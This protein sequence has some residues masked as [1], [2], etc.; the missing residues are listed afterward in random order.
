MYSTVL[1]ANAMI[2]K[3]IWGIR[4]WNEIK[5][6][7]N[8]TDR[9]TV[10]LWIWEDS[11]IQFIWDNGNTLNNDVVYKNEQWNEVYLYDKDLLKFKKF[12]VVQLNNS[13][14]RT[15]LKFYIEFWLSWKDSIEN[16]TRFWKD[17][18]FFLKYP[19]T[20]TLRNNK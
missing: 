8:S 19:I 5:W 1:K 2:I 7:D 9:A 17:N 12:K 4:F 3:G 16:A 20:Y 10:R 18:E 6:I 15:W 11:E 14:N 13:V